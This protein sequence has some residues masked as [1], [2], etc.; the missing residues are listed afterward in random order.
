M[1]FSSQTNAFVVGE[2]IRG[3]LSGTTAVVDELY[4]LTTTTGTII[5]SSV[6]GT[7]IATEN[8]VRDSD[9][10]T[11]ATNVV[12]NTQFATFPSFNSY[13][14]GL[15]IF[16][17]AVGPGDYPGETISIVLTN[18]VPGSNYAVYRTS[19]LTLL[20]SGT[21]A[22]ST[23]TIP[24]VTYVADFGIT[25]RVRKSSS[26]PQYIPL[27]TQATVKSSGVDVYIGQIEDTIF[28]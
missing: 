13:I 6:S 12:T 20:G 28:T 18:V 21:A 19:D 2:T 16:T 24:N 15:E 7:F 10:Q 4:Q 22:S 3:A 1:M 27:E 23:V 9:S 14:D 5:L 17:N 11:R 26:E 8:I 25:V